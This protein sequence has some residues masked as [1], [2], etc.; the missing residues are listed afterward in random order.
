MLLGTLA[1]VNRLLGPGEDSDSE[2]DVEHAALRLER[3]RRTAA[4]EIGIANVAGVDLDPNMDLG[5]KVSRQDM[6]LDVD[7]AIEGAVLETK[8]DLE[9]DTGESTANA[10]GDIGLDV[11]E[12]KLEKKALHAQRRRTRASPSPPPKKRK[13]KQKKG[14]AID[15]L[16]AG[17]A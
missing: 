9:M 10:S 14:D 7:M 6:D 12:E 3:D 5:E 16:F 8:K 11:A 4:N 13:K 1:R 17:L 2:T 15:A